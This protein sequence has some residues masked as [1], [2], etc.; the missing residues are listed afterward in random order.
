MSSVPP[1]PGVSRPTWPDTSLP[2]E[3]D[4]P[5][6]LQI[7]RSPQH[8][9]ST[10]AMCRCLPGLPRREDLS[11]WSVGLPVVRRHRGCSFC[12]FSPPC[13]VIHPTR[14]C[15]C[16][17]VT[18]VKV[19][20]C[21]PRSPLPAP[22]RQPGPTC[23]QWLCRGRVFPRDAVPVGDC[24]DRPVLPLPPRCTGGSTLAFRSLILLSCLCVV[25]EG[26][27]RRRD[28]DKRGVRVTSYE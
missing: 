19:T 13:C 9:W 20:A 12:L 5:D 28:D 17:F 22:S 14:W 2:G 24:R 3:R 11:W 16:R 6:E 15:G 8:P 10:V 23:F 1:L 26:Q 4:A 7:F 27:G 18:L 25:D 21:C